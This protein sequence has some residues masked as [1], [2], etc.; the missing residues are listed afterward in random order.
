MPTMIA[1][2]LERVLTNTTKDLVQDDHTVTTRSTVTSSFSSSLRSSRSFLVETSR[3]GVRFAPE[4]KVVV[5]RIYS[6]DQLTSEEKWKTWWSASEFRAIRLAAKFTTMH[7]RESDQDGVDKIDSG[8]NTALHVS[9]T[10]TDEELG[11][12]LRNPPP[13]LIRPLEKWCQRATAVRGLEK[14]ISALQKQLRMQYVQEA[15]GAVVSMYKSG[16]HSDEDISMIYKEYSRHSL[17]FSRFLGE[18]DHTAAQEEKPRP[19]RLERT[20]SRL[21]LGGRQAS[22][23]KLNR[24]ASQKKLAKQ[25]SSRKLERQASSKLQREPSSR[26]LERMS[27]SRK[28]DRQ[29]SQKMLAKQTSSRKLER[30]ASSKLQREPSSRKLEREHSSRKLQ[31]EPSSRNLREN[32]VKAASL[33]KI[34]VDRMMPPC[35]E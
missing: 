25:T 32:L 24:Q 21:G 29:A 34:L 4:E 35:Q 22:S 28:L 12:V 16:E 11:T 26:K 5:G 18:S 19:R 3:K 13:S 9:C 31:R 23:H 14:Y 6:L 15:R 30:Q 10:A 7:A 33:T 17:V 1:T 8:F 20:V 27:S 2:S